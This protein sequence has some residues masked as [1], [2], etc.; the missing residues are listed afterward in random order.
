MRLM[1]C[2]NNVQELG[3]QEK[4]LTPR[5]QYSGLGRLNI[6]INFT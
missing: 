4:E 2:G 3:F 5:C 1:M 6:F